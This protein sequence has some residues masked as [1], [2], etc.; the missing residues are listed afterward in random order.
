[1]EVNALHICEYQESDHS[2]LAVIYL[3][4][5]TKTFHWLNTDAYKP[6]D[7]DADT[8]GERVLVALLKDE[9]VGFIA[10]WE[11]DSFIHH[12]YVDPRWVDKGI[13]KALLINTLT[14]FDT[15]LTLKCLK[16][17]EKALSFYHSRGWIITGEGEDDGGVYFELASR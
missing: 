17:N 16:R 6:E 2:A 15:P 13:G 4:S 11:P 9:P 12:L 1:V 8:D 7:F 14:L 3:Q 10:I 5:R